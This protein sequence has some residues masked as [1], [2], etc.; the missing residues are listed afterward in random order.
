MTTTIHP[1][2]FLQAERPA[3]D[4]RHR[5]DADG[6]F[7]APTV[8]RHEARPRRGG[9]AHADPVGLRRLSGAGFD[10]VLHEGAQQARIVPGTD[11]LCVVV[12]DQGTCPPMAADLPVA[13]PA[14]STTVWVH[15]DGSLSVRASWGPPAL[16]VRGERVVMLP[17]VPGT[18]GQAVLHPGD[19]LIV[20]SSAAYESAPQEIVRLLHED[21]PGLAHAEAGD[22]LGNLLAQVPGGGGAVITRCAETTARPDGLSPR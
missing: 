14:A 17:E 12:A 15:A 13:A 4:T 8:R 19:R 7:G 1:R 11:R 10:V 5:L 6:S 2:P 18:T 22:L 9:R 20:L 16:L 3:P 21:P